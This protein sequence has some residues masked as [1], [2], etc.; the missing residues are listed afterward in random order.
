MELKDIR[1]LLN[2]YFH[3]E[4]STSANMAGILNVCVDEKD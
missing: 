4:R 1:E 2:V 3:D